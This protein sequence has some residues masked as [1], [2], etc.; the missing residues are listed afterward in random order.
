MT[1]ARRHLDLALVGNGR[2]GL[3]VDPEGAVVWG[4]YPRFDG[5]P[6]FCAL[7]DERP[8]ADAR[9]VFAIELADGVHAEQSYV[10]NTAVLSTP[11]PSRTSSGSPRRLRTRARASPTLCCFASGSGGQAIEIG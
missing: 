11:T 4:C 5:D 8:P 7:L 10:R 1:A 2:I 6:V 9:G 3:L